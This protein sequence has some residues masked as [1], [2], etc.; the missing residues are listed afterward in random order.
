MPSTTPGSVRASPRSTARDSAMPKSVTLTLPPGREQ[1]VA[2]LHVAVHHPVV[3]GVGEGVGDLGPE[4]RDLGRRQGVAGPQLGP[5]APALDELHDDERLGAAAPVV[6]PH[7]VGVVQA[8]RGPGFPLEPFRRGRGDGRR[9][10]LDRDDPLQQAVA[11]AVDVAHA[12]RT[13]PDPELVAVGEEFRDRRHAATL[14]SASCV[15][16]SAPPPSLAPLAPSPR[17]P[18]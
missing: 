14:P 3:V 15:T 17:K 9:R 2:R 11:G 16:P 8:R 12:A 6:D 5:Q 18:G 1:H 13:Q 10:H 4:R 7:D